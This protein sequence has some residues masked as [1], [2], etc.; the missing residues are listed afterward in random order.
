MPSK[1]GLTDEQ[2]VD[3]CYQKRRSV[4]LDS[5]VPTGVSADNKATMPYNEKETNEWIAHFKAEK[6]ACMEKFDG[7]D[8]NS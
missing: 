7:N 5:V 6:K 2:Q 8:P 3:A 1:A 4:N